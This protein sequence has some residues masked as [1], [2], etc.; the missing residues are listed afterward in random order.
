MTSAIFSNKPAEGNRKKNNGTEKKVP[1]LNAQRRT[2]PQHRQHC[3]AL[4][5]Q[6]LSLAVRYVVMCTLHEERLVRE[7]INIRENKCGR[8]MMNWSL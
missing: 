2:T 1:L 7:A 3:T 4:T 8:K 6:L 5:R